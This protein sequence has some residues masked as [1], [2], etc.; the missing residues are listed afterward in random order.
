MRAL[1]PTEIV[2]LWERGRSLHPLDQG[3]LAL[4]MSFPEAAGADV[5]DWPLGR[6]NQAIAELRRGAASARACA[7]QERNA[8]IAQ[9]RSNSRSTA[10]ALV[11]AAGGPQ[12]RGAV[13]VAGADV[14]PGRQA[15]FSPA[16]S[17]ECD[18]PEDGRG[19]A[20][21]CE[22]CRIGSGRPARGA[23]ES[24]LSPEDI[25]RIGEALALADPLA[26]IAFDFECPG[27]GEAAF[28]RGPRSCRVLLAR[29]RSRSE[30]ASMIRRSHA[31]FRLWLARGHEVLA[32]SPARRAFY[33]ERVLA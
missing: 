10:A 6:R 4:R 14:P 9:S 33:I 31:R 28:P 5:A 18:V 17:N 11:A 29:D 2:S 3:V 25:E 24:A 32:L 16:W 20:L 13:S 26:E 23:A 7:A 15:A 1:S 19:A 21:Q 30:A 27:C 22:S 12:D 8:R